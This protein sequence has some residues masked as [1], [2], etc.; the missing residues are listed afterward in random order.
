MKM[1]TVKTSKREE[2]IDITHQVQNTVSSMNIKNGIVVCFVPHT[3]A[4]ITINENADP[5]VKRDIIY[6][7]NKEV[8]QQDGYYHAEGNS[9]AHLKASLFGFS[10]HIIIDNGKL[11]L[12]TWQ[13]IY[14]CEF[15][16]PRTRNLHVKVTSS[17]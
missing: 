4:G 2:M 16:G 9:D 17:D 7:L 14:F 11:V 3:T 15:D 12:G 6:K 5:D 8:P 10:E 1:I 13:S